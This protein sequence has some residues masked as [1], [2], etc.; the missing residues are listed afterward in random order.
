MSYEIVDL[1]NHINATGTTIVMVTHEH[2]LVRKFPHRTITINH[3]EIVSDTD[4]RIY[5]DEQATANEEAY[6]EQAEQVNQ[7]DLVKAAEEEIQQAVQEMIDDN[8][9][10][11]VFEEKPSTYYA[12]PNSDLEL[13]DFMKNYGVDTDKIDYSKY[14]DDIDSIGGGN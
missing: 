6:T 7:A 1:L 5:R 11:D 13:E 2:D 4:K 14:L 10:V 12:Q 9:A 8:N 3:G